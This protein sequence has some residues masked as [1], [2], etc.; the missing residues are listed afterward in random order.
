MHRKGSVGEKH[1]LFR[2]RLYGMQ[3]CCADAPKPQFIWENPPQFTF[4]ANILF[5]LGKR[6]EQFIKKV[7][8]VELW[9]DSCLLPSMTIQ[10]A[11]AVYRE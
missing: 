1:L 2:V 7:K 4:N 5:N 10:V 9:I 6:D 8:S 3:C 11:I